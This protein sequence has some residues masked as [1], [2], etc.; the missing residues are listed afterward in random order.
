MTGVAC[1]GVKEREG[2]GDARNTVVMV[3]TGVAGGGG[4]ERGRRGE[5]EDEICEV[6]GYITQNFQRVFTHIGNELRKIF[7][8]M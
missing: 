8:V 1:G 3:V 2:R 4:K 5:S 7:H 6:E